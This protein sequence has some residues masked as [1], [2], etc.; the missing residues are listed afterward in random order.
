VT[1]IPSGEPPTQ[2]RGVIRRAV[3]DFTQ[4]VMRHH[5]ER[6]LWQAMAEGGEEVRLAIERLRE[7][8]PGISPQPEQDT[9][10]A[11]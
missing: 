3:D 7:R 2:V 8:F 9:P 6:A 10:H 1:A 11:A 4:A 5:A